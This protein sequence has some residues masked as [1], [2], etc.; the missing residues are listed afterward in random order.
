[1]PVYLE[2]CLPVHLGDGVEHGPREDDLCNVV[3]YVGVNAKIGALDF[4][5][6]N[7]PL[8]DVE[9]ELLERK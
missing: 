6:V 3:G 8:D 9:V 7:N 2:E 1:M 5:D 4:G